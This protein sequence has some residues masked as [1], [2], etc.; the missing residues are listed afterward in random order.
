MAYSSDQINKATTEAADNFVKSFYP[1]LQSNRKMLS[2]YY[3]DPTSDILFN[4]NFVASGAAVQQIFEKDMPPTHYEIQSYDCQLLN[5][6]YT[7]SATPTAPAADTKGGALNI[8]MILTVSGSVR[9]GESR[10]LPSRVFSETFVLVP[11]PNLQQGRK[12][13]R[14]KRYLIQSQN[15]RL[16]V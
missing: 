7:T 8:S 12:D 15:F 4:G 2:S 16:V 10:T 11:N 5:P 3:A 9:F 14:Q 13:P 6:N 1:A